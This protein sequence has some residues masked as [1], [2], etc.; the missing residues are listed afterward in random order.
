[1]RDGNGSTIA[2]VVVVVVVVVKEGSGR[3]ATWLRLAQVIHLGKFREMAGYRVRS[4]V[5]I[6]ATSNSPPEPAKLSLVLV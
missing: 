4:H 6:A 5:D 1:M 2:L 3:G